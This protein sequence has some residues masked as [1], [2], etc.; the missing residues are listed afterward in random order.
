MVIQ[1]GHHRPDDSLS[2]VRSCSGWGS[3]SMA[4]LQRLEISAVPW[5]LQAGSLYTCS[6]SAPLV[7][8]T[9]HSHP[10]TRTWWEAVQ[11]RK[12]ITTEK[13]S[14]IVLASTVVTVPRS[15]QHLYMQFHGLACCTKKSWNFNKIQSRLWWTMRAFES[16]CELYK[17][18]W[19]RKH[20][21][22]LYSKYW[23]RQK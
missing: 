14:K 6:R 10:H 1:W 15:E 12:F 4:R 20:T 9:R 13:G 16:V 17:S 18:E 8:E 22:R 5:A 7:G 2:E 23:Q 3:H 11:S 21:A 19:L